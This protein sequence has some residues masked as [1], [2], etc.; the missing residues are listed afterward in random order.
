MDDILVTGNSAE[1]HFK[2]LTEVLQKLRE[3][4]IRIR[5]SKCAFM[6]GLV[7][8][9]GHTIGSRRVHTIIRKVDVFQKALVPRNSQ[10]LC[11][12]LEILHYYGKYNP[13]LS[14]LF[15][16][17]NRLLQTSTEWKLDEKCDKAFKEVKKKLASA[18][19][20]AQYD[21]SKKLKL[22]ADASAYHRKKS[23]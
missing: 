12:F 19:I 14:R 22:A 9:L 15:H 20:M 16:P 3:H 8:Y 18:L 23:I 6:Q 21:T 17:L 13:N 10:Q 1:T 4:G 2:S 5:A 11:S 7:E